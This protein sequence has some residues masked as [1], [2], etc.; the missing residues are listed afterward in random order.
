M[1]R[2]V[3]LSQ[4]GPAHSDRETTH[5]WDLRETMRVMRTTARQ[6]EEPRSGGAGLGT[7]NN[8][9]HKRISLN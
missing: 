2:Q 3:C 6:R 9:L 7:Q 8:K 4:D 1:G 5:N